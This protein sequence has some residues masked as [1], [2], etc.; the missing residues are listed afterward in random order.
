MAMMMDTF[1][2]K[3]YCISFL[4]ALALCCC[5]R[6]FLVTE[7]GGYCLVAVCQLLAVVV[8]LVGTLAP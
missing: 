3:L 7:S 6:A 8:S 5:V 2:F 1:F 4:A